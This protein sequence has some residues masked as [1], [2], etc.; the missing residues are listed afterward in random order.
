VTAGSP[1]GGLGAPRAFAILAVAALLALA[2]HFGL[3]AAFSDPKG[4]TQTLGELGAW[5]YVAFVAAYTV[6]QP[7]GVPGTVFI[8]A[9]P[10]IW[11]WPIAFALSM[12]GTMA[13]SV[14]GFSFARFVA[15]DWVARRI[16]ARFGKYEDVLVTRAFVTVF[17]LRL[18]FWM[19]P[20]L[21][22]FFGVSKVGF[23]THVWGSLA[24]YVLP[25]FLVSF[26]GQKLFDVLKA[27]PFEVWLSVGAGLAFVALGAWGARK[28]RTP[29]EAAV[30]D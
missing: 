3:F 4:I 24:G 14:V 11:P 12:A 2:H 22:A 9:A 17:T 30:R 28:C 19:P 1:A 20:P 25:L 23:W 7:F 27:A 13:A 5:G 21:H 18:I 16:P 8:L 10:L 6:L 26:F 29:G 15:R